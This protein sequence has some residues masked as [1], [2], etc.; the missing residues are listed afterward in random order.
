MLASQ[1]RSKAARKAETELVIAAARPFP[2][3]QCR[4]CLRPLALANGRPRWEILHPWGL[5]CLEACLSTCTGSG[6][7]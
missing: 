4:R 7:A 2:I 6:R 3:P 1:T 5:V